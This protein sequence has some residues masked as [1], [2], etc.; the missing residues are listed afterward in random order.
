[1]YILSNI[2]GYIGRPCRSGSRCLGPSF[3]CLSNRSSVRPLFCPGATADPIA[4]RSPTSGWEASWFDR[5]VWRPYLTRSAATFRSLLPALEER[6]W[7]PSTTTATFAAPCIG[8]W[9]RPGIRSTCR[10]ACNL[11]LSTCKV[12][13]YT[14]L[15]L[16]K[17]F[18][19]RL[20]HI[21]LAQPVGISKRNA[22]PVR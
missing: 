19:R 12:D 22:Q 3:R 14:V 2:V 9:Q 15:P 20:D 6:R 4:Q 1:M 17:A 10:M 11:A 16:R 13:Q 5:R 21:E 7:T 18:L 8:T